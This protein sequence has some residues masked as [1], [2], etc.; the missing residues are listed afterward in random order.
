M[1]D[2]K[3]W[4]FDEIEGLKEKLRFKDSIE[5]R[6]SGELH[7]PTGPA[8]IKFSVD[9]NN[10]I[11]SNRY[12]LKGKEYDLEEWDKKTRGTKIKKLKKKIR[13]NG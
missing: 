7:N 9:D 12:F 5:Y 2:D 4:L 6:L 10:N 3:R 1:E 13:N 11:L 8:L